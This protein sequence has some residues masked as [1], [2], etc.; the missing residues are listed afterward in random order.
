MSSDEPQSTRD[1]LDDTLSGRAVSPPGGSTPPPGD[2]GPAA[3]FWRH[4]FLDPNAARQNIGL[5]CGSGVPGDLLMDFWPRLDE[6]LWAVDAPDEAVSL[7]QKFVSVSRSPTSLLALFHRDQRALPALLQVLSTSP[8][9]ADLLLTDPEGFDLI[10]ASDGRPAERDVLMDELTAELNTIRSPRRA[11]L[12]IANFAGREIL[13]IAYGEFVRDLPPG[14]AQKQLSH[15]ADA[16]L[17]AALGYAI[18]RVQSKRTLP[19]RIDGSPPRFSILAFGNYGGQEI[20]YDAV[21]EILLICD[22]ID[23]KNTDHVAF[24][25]QVAATMLKCFRGNDT[26][27]ASPRLKLVHQPIAPETL[28]D[29]RRLSQW[30][31]PPAVSVPDFYGVEEACA[32]YQRASQTWQ[33][34]AFVKSRWAAGDEQPATQF[35]RLTRSWVFQKM[36]SRS[37]MADIRVLRR[38]LEKRASAESSDSRM[39][40]AE[41]PG[42]RHD[43]ELTIQFLQLLYGGELPDVCVTG[44]IEAIA[45]LSRHQCLTQKEASIL[46]ENH[47]K[48]CRLEHHLAVLFEH[49][50]THLPDDRAVRQ[51]LAWRL[52]IRH[53][54][55]GDVDRM[56]ELLQSTFE[57]NRR[58]INHLMVDGHASAGVDSDADE[59]SS[60]A[61][62]G[63]SVLTELILDPSP[64]MGF[65]AG[66]LA[67]LGFANVPAAMDALMALSTETVSFLA[68][69]RCRHFFAAVAPTLMS[70]IG[71]TP[72]PDDTLRRL[73]DVTDSIGA[74][75]TL[76]ELLR[77]N[78]ATLTLVV[79]MT[80]LAPY[81]SDILIR[82]PGMID[83]LIDSL[84]RDRLPSGQRL[85]QQTRRMTENVDPIGPAL[86]SV[87]ASAHLT[88]GVRDLLD[89]ESVESIGGALSDASEACLQCVIDR[90]HERLASQFGDPVGDDG[91]PAELVAVGLQKFGGRE[92]NYHSDLD[93]AFLYTAE[94]Q[95]VRRVGG[96]RKT[97]SNRQFF[98]QV[99][100]SVLRVLG[101]SVDGVIEE[102]DLPLAGGPDKEVLATSVTAFIK[103][104]HQGT[105]SLWQRTLLC[106]ARV[107][108]GSRSVRE[109]VGQ[110][111][112]NA[113]RRGTWNHHDAAQ[114]RELRGLSESTV[115][116][117]NLKRGPGG[118]L[119]IDFIAAASV[120]QWASQSSTRFSPTT[121]LALQQL[122]DEGHLAGD[123]VAQLVENSLYLRR[124]EAKL[125]LLNTVSRHEL[126][127]DHDDSA[128]T[129]AMRKLA[130]LMGTPS[131]TDI[132]QRCRLVCR[133]NREIFDR[134]L[135]AD[136]A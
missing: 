133:S 27:V 100:Q 73:V 34:L 33:R 92:T 20:G 104:F 32:F 24:N 127:L 18:A 6:C 47:A 7:L 28:S 55:R 1:R 22:Q 101:P 113:L 8:T 60:D 15:V 93:V 112:N 111:L 38:K 12:A 131:P 79:R 106:K 44:T 49:R 16:M 11:A 21:L 9:I 107:V 129:L 75:A 23:R 135:G 134:L 67:E 5:I 46:S 26:G 50:T 35:F 85:D 70:E 96:P 80:G 65:L 120:M 63:A 114:L 10:R 87:K 125:R 56:E 19:Q 82:N 98:H 64:D 122:R 95:T 124:V 71:H 39:P 58:I 116:P 36:L 78:R 45:A 3:S 117:G 17:H 94:G 90:E 54:G 57:I 51:R 72:D 119:D 14:N 88:I 89:K 84:V 81:L 30:V 83:E 59:Q 126:P 76:W 103:P 115:R 43:I 77:T 132:V 128:D 86:R 105:A 97:L 109:R 42:G 108:S 102:I 52:G 25:Q 121:I 41:V 31:D 68:P 29:S 40:I 123:D 48:L 53:D 62:D 61:D 99:V 74:K 2:V 66:V 130:A 118:T 37:E 4:R 136:H 13:R 69:R 110:E 91:S